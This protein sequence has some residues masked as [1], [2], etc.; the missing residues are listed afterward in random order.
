LDWIARSIVRPD[1]PDSRAA[2]SIVSVFW[3]CITKLDGRGMRR[4]RRN[5]T[6]ETLRYKVNIL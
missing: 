2:S 1:N 6:R 5:A 4:M 3:S